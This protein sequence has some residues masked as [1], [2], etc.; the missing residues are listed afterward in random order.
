[1]NNPPAKTICTGEST[2]VSLL[3]NA[4]GANFYWTA[5]LTSGTVTGFSPDSGLVINQTLINTGATAGVVTYHITPKI[6]ECAGT[7]VDYIVTVNLGEPVDVSITA[8]GNNICAG[9]QVTFTAT[10]TNPGSNPVYQWKVNAINV[11]NAINAVFSYMPVNGDVVQCMLT[12]SN[13]ICTSNNPAMSNAI[14]MVVNPLQPVSVSVSAASNPV[15]AGTLVNFIAVPVN[16]GITPQYQW[17][18][19]AINAINGNNPTYTYVPVN[20]DAITCTLT[21]NAICPSGNP[22]MSNTVAMVVNTN[23]PAGITITASANPFCP[24]SAITFTATQVNGGS[25]PVYQWKVNAINVINANNAVYTYNPLPGDLVSCV[26]TSN[27]SCVT[28]NP[29]TS[30]P[31]VMTASNT[32]H[33]TFSPCFDTITST[34]AKP[35]KLRGALPIGG[36]YSG[37]G[38]NPATGIFSPSIA[39]PGT[40]L[41]HYNYTNIANCTNH[42]TA[43]IRNLSL[44]TFTCGNNLTDI[45]D[46][47]VYATVLIGSQCWMKGNLDFGLTIDDF[48]PQTD[49]CVAEKFIRYSIFNIQYSSFYQWDELMRYDPTPASQGLC[50]PGWHIPTSAEWDQ[51]VL[52]CNG[53]GQAGGPMKDTLLAT[54]FQSH[55][56]GFFYLNNTWAFTTG[57]SAGAMYWT[58]TSSGVRQAVARGL[59]E[60]NPSVSRYEAARGN[61]FTA[62]CLMD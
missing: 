16:G 62:R 48:V 9:T 55:Q 23:L 61:A 10:P 51:L 21:S 15:C 22:A 38:V 49:N 5:S 32:P 54:G 7:P 11:I 33:V 40:H 58:S 31:I 24:G 20:G 6:G 47:K 35:F 18:V 59:N 14:T 37:P 50:P 39:G 19:N 44:V 52:F 56:Q 13:T 27:L 46:N 29:V 42:A 53:S 45:R 43:V 2:Q 26:M 17:K 60:Y 12:S 8:S 57:L 25:S 1:L 41:I 36:N 3:S 34:N 30:A 4:S 28:T